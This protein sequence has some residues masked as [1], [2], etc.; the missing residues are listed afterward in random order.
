MS[1]KNNRIKNDINNFYSMSYSQ[2]DSQQGFLYKY[3]ESIEN[4]P[5]E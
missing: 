5:E 3:T 1:E 2:Y 4:N